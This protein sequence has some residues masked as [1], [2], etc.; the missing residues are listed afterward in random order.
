MTRRRSPAR[1]VVPILL[2]AFAPLALDGCVSV[3]LSRSAFTS[4]SEGSG[5]VRVGVYEKTRDRNADRPL[6]LPVC[7]ELVRLEGRGE[8]LVARSMASSW[9]LGNLPPGRYVLKAS[10]RIDANGDVVPLGKDVRKGFDVHAGEETRV[11]V[12]LS[13]VPVVLI[14]LAAVTV[15]ALAV[16]AIELLKDVDIP[17]PSDL[18]SPPVPPVVVAEVAMDVVGGVSDRDG[19]EPGVAD[20]FPAQGSVVTSPR[21]TVSFL[22]TS[23]LDGK[24]VDQEAVLALGSLSGEIPGKVSYRSSEQLLRFRPARDFSPGETVTVT[25]DLDKLE[26]AGGTSG[27]GRVT[28]N[29]RVAE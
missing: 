18:P 11:D 8:T 20:V 5:A 15:L 27:K 16:V 19:T 21:V 28:T 26:S 3:G 1:H 2:L 13:K 22:M 14:V 4:G 29:F 12:V 9:N 25:V 7:T 23:P 17:L 24:E 6:G 10:R